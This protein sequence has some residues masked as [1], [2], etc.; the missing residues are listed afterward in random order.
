M[1]ES[2]LDDLENEFDDNDIANLL[3]IIKY[4]D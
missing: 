1:E 3:N 2:L 4:N